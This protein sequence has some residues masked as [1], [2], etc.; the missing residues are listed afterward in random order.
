MQEHNADESHKDEFHSNLLSYLKGHVSIDEGDH[1]GLDSTDEEAVQEVPV[2][3]LST[4]GVLDLVL[5][6]EA[7]PSHRIIVLHQLEPP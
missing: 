1:N 2:R 6:L 5:L 7:A 4:E 3:L